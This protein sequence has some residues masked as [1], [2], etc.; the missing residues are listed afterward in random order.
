MTNDIFDP[1]NV[2]TVDFET[3][4]ST[5]DKFGFKHQTTEQYV[6]DPRWLT[7]G[8]GVKRGLSPSL[9]LYGKDKVKAFFDKAGDGL[10]DLVL[11]GHNAKFDGLVLSHHYG[12]QP[13]HWL[14]TR[15]LAMM[16]YGNNMKGTSL[17]AL[18]A[19]FLPGEEKDQEALF[20]VEGKTKLT[21]EE[22]QELGDYCR[23]DCDKTHMLYS[24]FY[25][26][27]SDPYAR[28]FNML[29]IDMVTRM[30]SDPVLELDPDPLRDLLAQE[31]REKQL[32]VEKSV[33]VDRKQLTSNQQF[34]T[35]LKANG[36][37]PPLKISPTTGKETLAFA[38]TDRPFM[39][40]LD[41]ESPAVR[42]LVAARLRVK[43]NIA[44]TR[45]MAYLD[46]SERGTW[47]V[48]LN[49]SG[50][51][52]THRL[53]GSSGGG[54]NP[55]NLGRKSPLRQAVIPPA[56][57]QMFAVDSSA[58]ELRGAMALAGEWEVVEKLKDPDYDLYS[59]FAA[60]IYGVETEAVTVA[61]RLVGKVAM[62]SLQYGTGWEGFVDTCYNW[63]IPIEPEESMR[64]VTLY[65]SAFP[66]I[67]KTWKH[68]TYMLHKLEAGVAIEWWNDDL[69]FANPMTQAECAGFTMP[70]TGLS[71]TYPD[72]RWVRDD[73]NKRQ[74]TYTRWDTETHRAEDSRIW[75]SKC[76]ENI[77]QALCR[78]VVFEQQLILDTHLKETYDPQCR[79]TMSIHDE[80]VGIVPDHV[81][82]KLVLRDAERVF[83][84][85]PSWWP[86]L[87]VFGEAHAGENYGQCK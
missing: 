61:Q 14:D 19:R 9:W 87:P 21:P 20:N 10:A 34:A 33:A 54:G 12:V 80:G 2:V 75:G 16:L 48:D 37:E 23:G 86:R 65:R 39:E 18:T 35:L 26:M 49:L 8:V 55:Q 79:T 28:R 83:A 31:L 36:V 64:I 4:F 66:K 45:A 82:M 25:R 7:H 53:S 6:R 70:M 46:V 63:G 29:T 47:P 52:T 1:T 69:I 42:D 73:E 59:V 78:N 50:A 27:M 77:C 32:A 41:H 38:K 30:F 17:K 76:F 40:L 43:T 56:G 71:I 24:L 67:T 57:F 62:L 5:K 85:S 72:L 22:I 15:S 74:L 44:E 58:V 51:R 11:V 60:Y 13:K 81:N 68:L 84:K 3:H